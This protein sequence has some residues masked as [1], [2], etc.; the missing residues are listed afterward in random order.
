M[1]NQIKSFKT[2]VII[3]GMSALVTACQ[4]ETFE[5]EGVSNPV[6]TKLENNPPIDNPNRPDTTGYNPCSYPLIR[7]Q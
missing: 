3:L 4:K 2:F 7:H 5:P 6:T 1:K